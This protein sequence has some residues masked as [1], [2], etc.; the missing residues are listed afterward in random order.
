MF[1]ARHATYNRSMADT[2]FQNQTS[3]VAP[4]GFEAQSTPTYE[5]RMGQ[6]LERAMTQGSLFFEGQGRVRETLRR[7][8]TAFDALNIPYAIVGGMALFA[9]GFRRFTEGV[10]ILVTPDGLERIHQ[11]LEGRGYVRP[12]GKSK[13]LR[14]ASTRVNIEFLTTGSDP[15]DGKE[16]P[17]CFPDPAAVV[18]G[19]QGVKYVNL[20]TPVDLKLAS[21]MSASNRL[22]DLADVQEVI[23]V[24]KVPRAFSERLNPYVR[25]KF[26]ELWDAS[27]PDEWDQG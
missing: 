3:A 24:P 10:D 16:K 7:I 21:G 25:D 19:R 13:H 11:E 1:R 6:D 5:Q 26:L 15:G 2:T 18:E 22:K 12:F 9:H 8:T 4:T 20:P 14:D 17:V 23:R 27:K